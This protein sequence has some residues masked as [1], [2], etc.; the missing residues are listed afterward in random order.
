MILDKSEICILSCS[1]SS[2]E[3]SHDTDIKF[4]VIAT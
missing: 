2:R 4:A 1:E 3:L